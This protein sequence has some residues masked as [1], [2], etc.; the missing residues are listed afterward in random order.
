MGGGREGNLKPRHL[1]LGHQPGPV[2]AAPAP[3]LHLI[4]LFFPTRGRWLASLPYAAVTPLPLR[5][6]KL[7]LPS[8]LV[9][10]EH[11]RMLSITWTTPS[12]TLPRSEWSEPRGSE[13]GVYRTREGRPA[14]ST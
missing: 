7:V 9:S 5:V 3:P 13:L 1:L 4:P 11:Q 8:P 14:S 10:H 2:S 12:Y 6:S